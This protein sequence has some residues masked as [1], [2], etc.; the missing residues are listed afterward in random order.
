MSHAPV[1]VTYETDLRARAYPLVPGAV[2]GGQELR[3]RPEIAALLG[4]LGHSDW[5]CAEGWT[6]V[7]LPDTARQ[8]VALGA[9]GPS[10]RPGWV[11]VNMLGVHPG[12]RG[13]GY[14]TRLHAHLLARAAE[15]FVMHGG[16][17]EAENQPMRRI[18]EKHGSRH[19]ATQLSFRSSPLDRFHQSVHAARAVRK[20]RKQRGSGCLQTDDMPG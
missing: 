4:A 10:N 12:S 1:H 14:G 16:A 8:P 9:F 3:Q 18:F 13:Q 2:E 7:A 11:N 20:A 6:L 17:T 5:D 15:R 19:D